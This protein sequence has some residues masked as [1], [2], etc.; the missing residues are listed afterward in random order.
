M[1]VELAKCQIVESIF[2]FPV[3]S[4]IIWRSIEY[5]WISEAINVYSQIQ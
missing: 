3:L 1:N 5:K 4:D 2:K